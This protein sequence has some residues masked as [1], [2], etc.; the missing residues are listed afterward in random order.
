MSYYDST[1]D[2]EDLLGLTSPYLSPP[3]LSKLI[4]W[5]EYYDTDYS[6]KLDFE[7]VLHGCVETLGISPREVEA[8]RKVLKHVIKVFD[9]DGDGLIDKR[10]F[11]TESGMGSYLKAMVIKSIKPLES[12]PGVWT[13]NICSRLNFPAKKFCALCGNQLDRKKEDFEEVSNGSTALKDDVRSTP[14]NKTKNAGGKEKF[15]SYCIAVPKSGKPGKKIRLQL[16]G[17]IY[18]VKIP[19]DHFWIYS[20]NKPAM[21]EVFLPVPEGTQ[22]DTLPSFKRFNAQEYQPPCLGY[23]NVK[24]SSKSVIKPVSC[25]KRALLIGIN[26]TDTPGELQSSAKNV[27]I[28]KDA[29]L[30]E[31]FKDDSR[32][33]VVLTDEEKSEM[34]KPTSRNIFKAMQWL[35]TD[36]QEG[37]VLFFYFSGHSA[38]VPNV[39][40]VTEKDLSHKPC[41]M[42]ILPS[43]YKVN[44]IRDDQLWGSLVYPLQSGVQLIALMD[45]C[46]AGTGLNTAFDHN[47]KHH[48][49]DVVGYQRSAHAA[50]DVIV[51][52]GYT[53][54]TQRNDIA[55]R[56]LTVGAMTRAFVEVL[57]ELSCQKSTYYEILTS[58]RT[59]LKEKHFDNVHPK[60]SSSQNFEIS[61]RLFSFEE[62]I[63]TNRNCFIGTYDQFHNVE[64]SRKLNDDFRMLQLDIFLFGRRWR[65]EQT[66]AEG[67][68][69]AFL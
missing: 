67:V 66:G 40:C 52:S 56:K 7:E 19:E 60:L 6:G 48:K 18:K 68:T 54:E 13:C 35:V 12:L 33:M 23:N 64:G 49:S 43:D 1:D 14:P 25:R 26:Y 27:N 9:K 31:G 58:L 37:D 41:F 17:K 59:A 34:Y 4:K 51:F 36:A 47:L 30:Q 3:P 46:H 2:S 45:C 29:L 38:I 22:K 5:F 10:E 61:E 63:F 8:M 11:T 50:G 16:G 15:K 28:M 53:E 24:V 32:H 20:K 57:N 39:K 44:L 55:V 21:F 62:E 42:T 69:N 65:V